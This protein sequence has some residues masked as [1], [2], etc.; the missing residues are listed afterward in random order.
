MFD[1][2]HLLQVCKTVRIMSH[3]LSAFDKQ[4]AADEEEDRRNRFSHLLQPIRDLA[5][6]FNIDLAHELEDYLDDLEECTIALTD[7]NGTRKLNFAEAALLIRGSSLIY[8]K[9]VDYLYDLV[10][11]VLDSVTAQKDKRIRVDLHGD[12]NENGNENEGSN[13]GTMSLNADFVDAFLALDDIVEASNI[14]LDDEVADISTNNQRSEWEVD[15]RRDEAVNFAVPLAFLQAANIRGNGQGSN[16][17][18]LSS[19]HVHPSGALLLNPSSSMQYNHLSDNTTL[20]CIS[21]GGAETPQK[22]EF[23]NEFGSGFGSG[24]SNG[25]GMDEF[26]SDH[27]SSGN[28]DNEDMHEDMHDDMHDDFGGMDDDF[29]GDGFDQA[30]F[31]SVSVSQRLFT[32][33]LE[34]TNVNRASDPGEKQ[35]KINYWV[36]HGPHEQVHRSNR[37]FRTGM[38]FVFVL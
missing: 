15:A 13:T 24:F 22:N 36:M 33:P 6:N 9:K 37:P 20:L 18:K 8:S 4:Q 32:N 34:E 26:G 1:T 25:N 38:C 5:E 21:S 7:E 17:F 23:G 29:G 19:S 10:F 12:D 31:P 35:E 27:F 11:K 16:N 30:D 14:S 2:Q 28:G 3:F